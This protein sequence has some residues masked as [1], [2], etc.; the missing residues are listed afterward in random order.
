MRTNA[1]PWLCL[2][3]LLSAC[4]G[5]PGGPYSYQGG[6]IVPSN[7]PRIQTPTPIVLSPTPQIA[8]PE[9]VPPTETLTP[10]GPPPSE[11]PTLTA[12]ATPASIKVDILGCDTS[13]DIVH[14]M[15]EVTNA[16]VT[17]G[18]PTGTDLNNVCATL[19]GLDEAR[20]HPDKTK[21]VTTLPSG[22][23]VTFKLTIDTT[24]EAAT[25]IQVDVTTGDT[26][27]SRVGEPACEAI[28]VLL[29]GTGQMGVIQP[30]PTP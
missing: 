22:Y 5:W 27:L 23:Q 28:G 30:I 21:C 19:R 26:L 17:I 6:T 9:T 29:P 24:Y 1:F 20:P 15:G 18:N 25:P 13:I 16:Y 14:G 2:L 11:T 4:S 8:T 12:T 3:C 7:T 10:A